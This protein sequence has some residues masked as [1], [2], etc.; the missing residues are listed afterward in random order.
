M[1]DEFTVAADIGGDEELALRHGFQRLERGDE[2]G[3]A[4]RVAR[5]GE[6]VDQV[7]IAVDFA[8]RDAAGEDDVR[9]G[10]R[11]VRLA[12]EVG[13]LGPPPTS[14]TSRFRVLGRM[15]GKASSSR[16]SPS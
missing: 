8:M 16:S 10:R 7:V 3:Q 1:G 6:D 9:S 15:S 5:V 14:S 2:L 11:V 12:V 4:H 13:F